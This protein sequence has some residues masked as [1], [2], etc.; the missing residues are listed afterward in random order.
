[1]KNIVIS[2]VLL[3]MLGLGATTVMA[4]GA[5]AT[6]TNAS[7]QSMLQSSNFVDENE[8]GVCDLAAQKAQGDC[9]QEQTQAQ[10]QKQN[11]NQYQN[12]VQN[13]EQTQTQSQKR[14]RI[15]AQENEGECQ[16]ECEKENAFANQA[17]EEHNYSK[18]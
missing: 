5:S 7:Q 2:S 11:R 1:M 13:Q 17:Q 10:E 6:Q 3:V 8:D 9:T 18:Q 16:N 14:E 4:E 12:E 15:Q